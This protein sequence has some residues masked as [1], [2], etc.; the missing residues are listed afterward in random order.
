M[1]KNI[2]KSQ[3]DDSLYST[4]A[5]PRCHT[6]LQK[7][8][9]SLQCPSCNKIYPITNGV[10]NFC[11]KEEYWCNVSREKMRQLIAQT[12]ESGDWLQAVH[13]LIPEYR[14][15]IEPF[16]RADAQFLFHINRTAK[17][18]D[19]G[20]MWGG[21]TIPVAQYCK[22]IFAVDKTLETLEFL[23][24]R[25]QQMGFANVHVVASP[26]RSLPFPDNSFDLV[27]L[28]GVLEWVAFDQDII[29]EAHWGKKRTDSIAVYP[30][31]PRDMQID[32]L[33]EL[34]RVLKPGGHIYV[35]IENR[36]GYQ[37]FAGTPDDHVNL[38]F[39]SFLPRFL[40]N[41]I[42]KWK[43]NFEYRTYIYTIQGLNS[44]LKTSGFENFEF[45]SAFPHYINP[46]LVI[47][48]NEVKYWEKEIFQDFKFPWSTISK[49]FPKNLLKFFS[50]SFV[51][52]AQKTDN[53]SKETQ[54]ES[55]II[56]LCKKANLIPSA[57]SQHTVIKMKGR[58]GNYHAVNYLVCFN[59]GSQTTYFCKI[60]R[61]KV[62]Q[63]I[64]ANEANNLQLVNQL[65]KDTEIQ[66]NIPTFVFFD[67][68][69]TIP[70]L[71]TTYIA[72]KDVPFTP[73][74]RISA[75]DL[76]ALD[77]FIQK[78]ID[79]LVKFQKLTQCKS[80][81]A[82]SYLLATLKQQKDVLNKNDKCKPEINSLITILIDEIQ[83]IETTSIPICAIHGDYDFYHNIL[84]DGNQVNV[85]D[86]EH[87]EREGLP[88]LDFATLLLNPFL[89]SY[90]KATDQKSFTDFLEKNNIKKYLTKWV[91]EYAE[92]S[93]ISPQLLRFFVP[94]AALEQ[95]TKTYPY[96]REART[97]PMYQK[98]IFIDLLSFRA[99]V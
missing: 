22:E 38:R 98:K 17:V 56:R 89:I 18:L 93:G 49:M 70:F 33:R 52:M 12:Q 24:L 68:I 57:S 94:L 63:D 5:C 25:A 66:S 84:F 58:S 75:K 62:Y 65:V 23:K 82:V 80:V 28:N 86:F 77:P 19:A 27:I 60:C 14:M 92:H 3:N 31:K 81:D 61:D 35:G 71:V 78:A 47:P 99:P 30:K 45:Y 85:V 11:K 40:A 53:F 51:L 43:L 20:S 69:D 29:L 67:T 90:E 4:L 96:Y 39:V 13:Q 59:G 72:G 42:T 8:Q 44:L 46:A 54:D 95:Q 50:P 37:Y 16:D 97:F 26:L 32:V 9:E 73:K 7:K 48:S 74:A 6:P 21:V 55:R 15:H 83:N 76:Y 64:L 36:F 91:K 34:R 1:R 41:A 88:F 10:P 2:T 87:F 79:F